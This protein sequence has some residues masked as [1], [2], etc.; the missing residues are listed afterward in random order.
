MILPG[1]GIGP[2]VVN[3]G[4]RIL[5][6]VADRFSLN[7]QLEWDDIGW[8]AVERYGVPL[9][10]ITLEKGFSHTSCCAGK[11]IAALANSFLVVPLEKS[12]VTN[13]FLNDLEPFFFSLLAESLSE[14]DIDQPCAEPIPLGSVL[15]F[16]GIIDQGVL[17]EFFWIRR[18]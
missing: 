8:S 12:S 11:K 4:V 10:E 7:L 1:D 9:A 18:K 6:D 3:A 15:V 13:I 2:E 17:E 5:T 14:H 16:K